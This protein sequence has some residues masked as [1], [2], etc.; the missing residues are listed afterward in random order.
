M[1]KTIESYIYGNSIEPKTFGSLPIALEGSISIPFEAVRSVADQS[2]VAQIEELTQKYNKLLRE[3]ERR[4]RAYMRMG[5]D[6]N[7]VREENERLVKELAEAKHNA[8]LPQNDF[9]P[10]V[11]CRNYINK[12]KQMPKKEWVVRFWNNMYELACQTDEAGRYIINCAEMLVPVY[13]VMTESNS[14]TYNFR[15]SREDFEYQWNA[16]VVDRM[17]DK[18]RAKKLTCKH[19]TLTTALSQPCWKNQAPYRW[20]SLSL[21]GTPFTEKYDK[22]VIIKTSIENFCK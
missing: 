8:G 9:I 10:V 20:K 5:T 17:A 3:D 11:D 4:A 7:D 21:E 2:L 13:K 6:L 19:K 15:G 1:S 16:N 14:M 18:E 12:Q 22:G